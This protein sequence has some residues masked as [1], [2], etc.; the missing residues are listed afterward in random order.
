[1][2]LTNTVLFP[3]AMLPLYIFEP[4]YRQML[5]DVLAGDR[6]FVVARENEERGRET[7][8]FE[9]PFPVASVGI[10][11]ACQQDKD[12]CSHLILQGLLRVRF[13]RIVQETPYRIG[14]F[15][16]LITE[17]GGSE[18]ELAAKRQDLAKLVKERQRLGSSAPNEVFDFLEGFGDPETYL[19]LASFT[20]CDDNDVKQELLETLNASQ[21]FERLRDYLLASNASLT[22]ER[23]LRGNLDSDEVDRN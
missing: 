14:E 22:L 2:T 6:L 18:P 8:E 4:R 3:H 15:D 7:D 23:K 10:I 21:R 13:Q 9:P 11:R 17:S 12:G 1:M 16:H 19:D 20:L 5:E